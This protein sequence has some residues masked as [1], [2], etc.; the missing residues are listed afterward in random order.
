MITVSNMTYIYAYMYT[1]ININI[2]MITIKFLDIIRSRLRQLPLFMQHMCNIENNNPNI[3]KESDTSDP[4]TITFLDYI[5]HDCYVIIHLPQ[6]TQP[7]QLTVKVLPS[8]VLT[9]TPSFI[10]VLHY[11][12]GTTQISPSS[13]NFSSFPTNSPNSKHK[14]K[15]RNN[16]KKKTMKTNNNTTL[17]MKWYGHTLDINKVA[18]QVQENKI[19]EDQKHKTNNKHYDSI[20]MVPRETQPDPSSRFHGNLSLPCSPLHYISINT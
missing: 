15:E 14:R 2:F 11:L 3:D 12:L 16:N 5:S 13:I 19:K 4:F 8:V 1:Y 20:P 10:C 7:V 18:N 17:Q 9:H 6:W